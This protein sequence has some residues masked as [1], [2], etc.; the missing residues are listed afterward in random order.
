MRLT[1]RD[2]QGHP[3]EGLT[4]AMVPWMAEM[5]HGASVA[6]EVAEQGAGV[7]DWAKVY[8]AMPGR[9][10]LRTTVTGSLSDTFSVELQ[11]P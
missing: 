5:G 4:L 11:I 10:Q 9:W 6:P 7:Y 1:L 8:L 3:V 2:R